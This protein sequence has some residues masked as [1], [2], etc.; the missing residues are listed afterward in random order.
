[1]ATAPEFIS[2]KAEA[3]R[4]EIIKLYEELSGKTL[5]PGQPEM[6]LIDMMAYR[7]TILRTG[8]QAAAVQNLVQFSSAPVLDYLG[9]IVGVKR[10]QAE[11]ATCTLKF[12]NNGYSDIIVQSGFRVA[13]ADGAIVF[14]TTEEKYLNA[15]AGNGA[16]PFI[17]IQAEATEAGVAGNGYAIGTINAALDQAT[18]ETG[19]DPVPTSVIVIENS[20]LTVGGT[21]TEQDAGLR[22]RILL[23]PNAFSVAG[24]TEAYRYWA[25]TASA[26]IKDVEVV[27]PTPG[28]VNIVILPTIDADRSSGADAERE[29]AVL[30]TVSAERVRPLCDTV[31]TDHATEVPVIITVNVIR[32]SAT[33]AIQLQPLLEAALANLILAG[34]SEFGKSI[35]KNEIIATFM[36]IA[37]VYNVT[38]VAPTSDITI[39]ATSVWIDDASSVSITGVI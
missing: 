25:R 32:R 37:G 21:D 10:L 12:K 31:T 6:L 8:I 14:E 30:A 38:V 11:P 23:A 27:S 4:A 7:E 26:D 19:G 22:E 13:S 5:Q 34:R 28:T 2:R 9:D 39:G 35:L 20:T 16:T 1:M 24:P 33:P 29:A 3:I 18:Y 17:Y 15:Q 36:N